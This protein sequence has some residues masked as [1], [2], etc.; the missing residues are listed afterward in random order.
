MTA[1]TNAGSDRPQSPKS[2]QLIMVLAFSLL[3]LPLLT[4]MTLSFV[5]PLKDGTGNFRWSLIWYGK[6]LLNERV[7]ES[8]IRSLLIAT[9]T[10]IVAGFI[11]TCGA[12]AFQRGR[13]FGLTGLRILAVL[14]LALPELVLGLSSLL[15]FAV[16][17]MTLGM[18]SMIAAH[19]TFTVSYV[20]II[21]LARLKDLDRSLEDAAADLGANQ[22]Q[23]LY[24]VIWPNIRNAVF[25]GMMMAF[26]LSFD[27][28]MISF[29]TTGVDSD[30][31]PLMLYSMIRFGLNKEIYALSSILVVMTLVTCISFRRMLFS[32]NRSTFSS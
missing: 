11:G 14:P 13:F 30:T 24:L 32:V 4:V 2:S 9:A 21:V 18:H 8:L 7:G 6:L 12:I 15:W 23:I 22:W 19:I 28:F 16:L 29:F 1:I 26:V 20:L 5:E 17:R 10:A 25:G 27:D 31:L 3:F